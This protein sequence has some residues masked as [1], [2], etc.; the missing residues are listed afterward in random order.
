ML[1][2]RVQ[3]GPGPQPLL[4]DL[5]WVSPLAQELLAWGPVQT[6][7]HDHMVATWQPHGSHMVFM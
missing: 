2:A 3:G 1:G 6:L 5:G 4:A 7:C